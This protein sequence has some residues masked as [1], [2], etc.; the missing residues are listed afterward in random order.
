M[1]KTS[2]LTRT[3]LIAAI[4]AC[5]TLV[6]SFLSFGPIQFRISEAMCVL[7][8]FMPEAVWGL[9]AGCLIANAV[10]T[11]LGAALPWDILFGT[12]ATFISAVVTKKIKNKWLLPLPTVLF[13]GIIVGTML[14]FLLLGKL[15]TAPLLYNIMTVSLGEVVVCYVVGIPLFAA[16]ERILGG[17]KDEG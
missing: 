17:K 9:T 6:F 15:E 1:K 14:T 13:N 12:L 2:Y 10:G 16:A 11:A 7:I 4:Y 5:L 8:Y 3:A